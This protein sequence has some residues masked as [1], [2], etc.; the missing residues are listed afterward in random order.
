MPPNLNLT[1]TPVACFGQNTGSINVA[2]AGG[3]SPLNFIWNNSATSQNLSNLAAGT[4]T[5]TVTDANNCRASPQ[6]ATITQPNTPLSISSNPSV[7]NISCAGKND[8]AITV[9]I[10]GG[11]PNYTFNWSSLNGFSSPNQNIIN[12]KK[13]DYKLLVTDSKNCTLTSNV[14]TITE[15]DSLKIGAAIVGNDSC[16]KAKGNIT[17]ANIIGGNGNNKFSWSNNATTQNLT[18]L[19]AGNYTLTVRDSKNCT[20][21]A[22]FTLKNT[23]ATTAPVVTKVL[24]PKDS[25]QLP[26][27]RIWIKTAGNYNDSTTNQYGCDSI[28]P[29]QIS[30]YPKIKALN[31]SLEI[32]Q[33]SR[34]ATIDVLQNDI[35]PAK[36]LID[37][38]IL[39]KLSVGTL[40]EKSLGVYNVIMSRQINNAVTFSY[41]MCFKSCPNMCDSAIVKVIMKDKAAL[42]HIETAITPNGDG[43]NDVLDLPDIDWARYPDNR[44]EIYNRWGQQVYVAQPYNRDWAGQ[45]QN[46]QDLPP[47]DYFIILRLSI[48]DGKILIGTVYLQR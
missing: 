28:M 5:L 7:S 25:F 44:L 45:N 36:N 31:D 37:V 14:L 33:N 16:Q 19:T 1:T 42:D 12:L 6:S 18:N 10:A 9:N 26:I 34:E 20:A 48:A 8:G 17:V 4:Y 27:R 2:V 24:C 23:S 15:P 43:K 29:Y 41:Q 11:T 39:H 35:F 40:D 47:G 21:T 13:G 3:T 46:G 30:F 32:P 38:T 22:S